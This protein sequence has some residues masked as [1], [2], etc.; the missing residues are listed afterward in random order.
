MAAAPGLAAALAARHL[1]YSPGPW[2]RPPPGATAGHRHAR[3]RRSLSVEHPDG[4]I[5]QRHDIPA[6]LI[7]P[8]YTAVPRTRTLSLTTLN[9][10]SPESPEWTRLYLLSHGRSS[11][12]TDLWRTSV[13]SSSRT[14]VQPRRRTQPPHARTDAAL[15][16]NS[17]PPRSL[18]VRSL[19]AVPADVDGLLPPGLVNAFHARLHDLVAERYCLSEF[20]H[21]A[22]NRSPTWCRRL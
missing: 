9:R 13:C 21:S 8:N 4:R 16:G 15:A 12:L 19:Q 22:F 14:S 11:P 6:H 2:N 17:V 7:T 1:T 20:L 18:T 10:S 5:R 3:P